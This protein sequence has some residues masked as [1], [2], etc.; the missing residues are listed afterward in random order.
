MERA[1]STT[2]PSLK[3]CVCCGDSAEGPVPSHVTRHVTPDRLQEVLGGVE[4]FVCRRGSLLCQMAPPL[5][6]V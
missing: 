3:V 5:V 2:V 4:P 1:Y 6:L